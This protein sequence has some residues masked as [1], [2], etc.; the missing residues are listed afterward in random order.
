MMNRAATGQADNQVEEELQALLRGMKQSADYQR[1]RCLRE[2]LNANPALAARIDEYRRRAYVMQLSDR[3]LYD[4]TDYVLGEYWS[5]M[6]DPLACTYLD[7]ENAVCRMLRRV[8]TRISEEIHVDLP[9][10]QTE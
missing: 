9:R 7:A 2:K 10:K 3:D 6:S 4:E 1:Y 8:I 5:L